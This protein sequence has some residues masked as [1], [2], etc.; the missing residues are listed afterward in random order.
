M[1]T[2]QPV[3]KPSA[4]WLPSTGV[5]PTI[6]YVIIVILVIVAIVAIAVALMWG[7]K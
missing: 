1:Y 3:F 4:A 2:Y 6:F 7:K 5:D